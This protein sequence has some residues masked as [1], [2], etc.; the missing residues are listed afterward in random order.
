MHPKAL[1]P[2]QRWQRVKEIFGP[3][4][5]QDQP[6]QLVEGCGALWQC[7]GAEDIRVHLQTEGACVAH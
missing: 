3:D 5:D 6:Q 2:K 4:F 7:I 1:I